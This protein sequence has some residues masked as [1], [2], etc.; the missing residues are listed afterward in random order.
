[1]DAFHTAL[2]RSHTTGY[3][4]RFRRPGPY[5]LAQSFYFD[6]KKGNTNEVQTMIDTAVFDVA[7]TKLLF[8]APGTHNQQRNV[9]IMEKSRDLRKLR[10]ASFVAAN[11]DMIVNLDTELEGFRAEIERGE[12]AQVEWRPGSGGGGGT[13]TLPMLSLLIVLVAARKTC[14]RYS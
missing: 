12:R 3:A 11:D 4:A 1:M 5:P 6:E 8:R 7:T 9:T 13:T 14:R 2:K 10:S